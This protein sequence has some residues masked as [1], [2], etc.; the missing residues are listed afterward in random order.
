MPP[1]DRLLREPW[2]AAAVFFYLKG[3]GDMRTNPNIALRF[4]ELDKAA[5]IEL[6]QRLQMNRTQT[7]R[8]LVRETLAVLKERE[9]REQEKPVEPATQNG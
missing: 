3:I 9:A 7:I 2:S 8:V 6:S 4:N 1:P 5:L